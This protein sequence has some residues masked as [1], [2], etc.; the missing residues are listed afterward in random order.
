MDMDD[1]K[2]FHEEVMDFLLLSS[3]HDHSAVE[4]QKFFDEIRASFLKC[5]ADVSVRIDDL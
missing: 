5:V 3:N 4:D 2:R 1:F